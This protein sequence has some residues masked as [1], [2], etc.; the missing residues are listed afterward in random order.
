MTPISFFKRKIAA[1][2][3]AIHP[4]TREPDKDK[5]DHFPPHSYTTESTISL[6]DRGVERADSPRSFSGGEHF[7]ADELALSP[8]LKGIAHIIDDRKLVNQ[9]IPVLP[10]FSFDEGSKT[11]SIQPERGS[12]SSHRKLPPRSPSQV[13]RKIGLTHRSGTNSPIMNNSSTGKLSPLPSVSH[14]PRNGTGTE[15]Q[16]RNSPETTP[17]NS[18]FAPAHSGQSWDQNG[19][20]RR[21]SSSDEWSKLPTRSTHRRISSLTEEHSVSP[22]QENRRRLSSSFQNVDLNDLDAL[23]RAIK[24]RRNAYGDDDYRVGQAWNH[25]GNYF[26]RNQDYSRALDAY[27]GA[28]MCHEGDD[29]HIGAAYG[30][31]GTVYWMTGDLANAV[32]FLNKALEMH[33]YMESVQGLDP[34]SSTAVSNALYQIGLALSLQQDFETAM[35]TLKYCRRVREKTLGSKHLDLARTIDAIGKIHLFRGELVDAMECHQ[36]ALTMKRELVSD[37]DSAVI[38]SL[39]N[40]AAVHEARQLYDEAIFTYMA[41]LTVQKETFLANKGGSNA[42]RIAKEAGET[43][44]VLAHLHELNGDPRASSLAINESRFFCNEAR[45]SE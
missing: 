41:V 39:M 3:P 11:A 6:G 25:I 31:I 13:I 21:S 30:N 45:F 23:K 42:S 37:S 8:Q 7:E 27:K 40:I 32:T 34:D 20:R 28:V 43:L 29:A 24:Q 5:E 9:D 2:D 19:S 44:Q 14:S 16:R 35:G 22:P 17:G 15:Q 33:R 10:S 26:F 36:Q 18:A 4:L 1:V 12:A 38:T